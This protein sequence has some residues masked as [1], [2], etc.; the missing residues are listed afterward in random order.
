M[1]SVTKHTLIQTSDTHGSWNVA[2]KPLIAT[3][4][5]LLLLI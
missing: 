5:G 4:N 2:G 1:P 3:G